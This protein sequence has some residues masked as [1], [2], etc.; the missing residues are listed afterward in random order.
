MNNPIVERL[1]S[2]IQEY[3]TSE[4]FR[5]VLSSYYTGNLRSAVVMLYATVICDMIYKL[6]K[7]SSEFND[8]RAQQILDEVESQWEHNPTSPDWET[9]L[10]KKCWES[11]K[12]LDAASHSNFESLQKLRHLCAHPAMKGNRELYQPSS[13]IVL[14]HIVNMLQEILTKPALNSKDFVDVFLDDLATVKDQMIT[15]DSLRRYLTAR[16]FD[17]Y[18]D[19]AL[20]YSLFKS[21]W[22]L[23]FHLT[24]EQCDEN[25]EVNYDALLIIGDKYSS[26]IIDRF[27]K[28]KGLFANHIAA[29]ND[30]LLRLFIKYVNIHIEFYEHL[31]E[32][33]RIRIVSNIN[34]SEDLKAL[35]I[36]NSSNHLDHIR[37]SK[38][39]RGDTILYL[40]NYLRENINSAESLDFNIEQYGDSGSFDQADWRYDNL[41]GPYL[42]DF[43]L[44]QW[45]R[46]LQYTNDNGQIYGRRKADLTYRA[47]KNVIL[48]KDENF[49]FTPYRSFGSI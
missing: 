46:I 27:D 19:V 14:G 11:H 2:Q 21:L 37:K 42:K 44:E 40:S 1:K 35:A 47:M 41:I 48:S 5:E 24:N 34:S 36:F 45:K 13:E 23:V 4:H 6:E 25:R 22:K 39:Q 33:V 9:S 49:D 43:T 17:K 18:D 10:P 15:I 20:F 12:I 28:D 31:P 32:D 3:R 7:L 30:D 16:Y 26:L 8:A 38:P 29:D